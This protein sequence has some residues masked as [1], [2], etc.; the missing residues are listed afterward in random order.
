[1][2]PAPAQFIVRRG[3]YA[4][5]FHTNACGRVYAL[6]ADHAASTFT[7]AEAAAAAAIAHGMAPEDVQV[8]LLP[9]QEAA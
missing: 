2:N 3:N 7:D 1:V 5:R 8:C 9:L 4:A 6:V